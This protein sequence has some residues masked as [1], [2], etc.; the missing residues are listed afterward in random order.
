MAET[1]DSR[2][3]PGEIHVDDARAMGVLKSSR[4]GGV[5]E[6]IRRHRGGVVLSELARACS[7]PSAAVSESIDALLEIGLIRRI[8][9]RG[10]QGTRYAAEC[11]QITIIADPDRPE[12]VEAVRAHFREAT[13]DVSDALRASERSTARLGDHQRRL[14]ARLKFDLR[15]AEWGELLRRLRSVYDYLDNI[16]ATRRVA[17]RAG[18]HACDHVL[19]IQLAP[20]TSPLLPSPLIRVV[21]PSRTTP[22][23]GAP[24]GIARLTPRERQV[25]TMVAAGM[26]RREIAENIGISMNTVATLLRRCYRKLE[27]GGR[28]ALRQRLGRH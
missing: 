4:C 7:L 15:P 17:E 20:T 25:A 16:A 26:P 8:R 9:A 11:Q 1:P 18:P 27:V 6:V 21:G 2:R 3:E 22:S 13:S 24:A 14:D 28:T 12:H 10:G 19:S 5:F 23:S